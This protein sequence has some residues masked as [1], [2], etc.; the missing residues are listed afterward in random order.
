MW[1]SLTGSER[2]KQLTHSSG[3]CTHQVVRCSFLVQ[4]TIIDSNSRSDVPVNFD[5]KVNLELTDFHTICEKALSEQGVSLKKPPQ[6][7]KFLKSPAMRSLIHSISRRLGL[8]DN[9]SDSEMKMMFRGCAFGHAIHADSSW[10]SAFSKQELRLIELLEDVD[11]YFGD[12]YGR[13]V[14]QKAPCPV[15]R[16]LVS[17]IEAIV[18]RREPNPKRTFLRFSHAGAIKQLISYFGLFDQLNTDLPPT[19]SSCESDK[20]D[21]RSRDWRSSL[22]SPF[23]ANIQFILYDCNPTG[24]SGSRIDYRLLTLLQESPV[25]VRGCGGELCPLDQFL[26]QYRSSYQCNLKKICRI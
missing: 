8:E 1:Q 26:A 23:S 19:S 12:A 15:A 18:E 20:W 16:D 14:N 2:I 3:D 24:N 6:Y 25:T 17:R 4:N 22:I 21:S 7:S 10:C 9:V 13:E 11:D 5:P